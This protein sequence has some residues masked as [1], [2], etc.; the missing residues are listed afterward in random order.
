[1]PVLAAKYPPRPIAIAPAA[2]SAKPAV[3]MMPLDST[4]PDN[5]AARANGTVR[6]SDI[7]ITMSRT[8]SV[9]V[10]CFSTCGVC[11][12]GGSPFRSDCVRGDLIPAQESPSGITPCPQTPRRRKTTSCT[13]SIRKHGPQDPDDLEW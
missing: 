1:A 8:A 12:I 4:A 13:G 11:G 10:K 9:E 7:P 2:T 5:P 3:T 6:P